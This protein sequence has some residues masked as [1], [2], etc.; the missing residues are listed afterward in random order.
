MQLGGAHLMKSFVLA[1][2][3]SALAVSAHAQSADSSSPSKGFYFGASLGAN[4]LSSQDYRTTTL[5]FTRL[6]YTSS[7]TSHLTTQDDTALAG[8][9]TFGR[10]FANGLRLEVEAA[11][12]QN[13]LSYKGGS[14]TINWAGR[15]SA[16]AIPL[17]VLSDR[18]IHGD[19]QHY[20]FM[21]NVL[22]D[23][24]TPVSW[25]K[26][27]VGV[28]AGL[29][30]DRVRNMDL[31]VEGVSTAFSGRTSASTWMNGGT[32]IQP[33]AAVQFIVGSAFP[34]K[35]MPGLSLTADYHVLGSVTPQS[36]QHLPTNAIGYG[37]G[38]W[39]GSCNTY[40]HY[41]DASSLAT[42]RVTGGL[43]QTVMVGFRYQMR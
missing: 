12:G 25:A 19:Y 39:G 9:L 13:P 38:N 15:G 20:S 33:S 40:T 34:L 4:L 29:L 22:Y 42:G 17:T 30:V 28:G 2:L 41:C 14:E 10:A 5:P 35:S 23:V 21:V 18:T 32:T 27:Y 36:I 43:S 8:R 11:G 7:V 6:G 31:I 16:G 37:V 24:P 1:G 26:P 3:L